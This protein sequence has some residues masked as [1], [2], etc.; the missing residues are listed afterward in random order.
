MLINLV[1]VNPDLSTGFPFYNDGM[2]RKTMDT[3]RRENLKRLASQ[4]T[5]TSIAK[6]MGW[7]GPS[8]VSQLINGHRPITEKTARRI[9]ERFSLD[10]RWMDREHEAI[11][12]DETLTMQAMQ[13]VARVL[14]E[15]G[16]PVGPRRMVKMVEIAV[17]EA[18]NGVIDEGVVR[19]MVELLKEQ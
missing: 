14:Q 16:V 2:P 17:E 8:Y 15:T 9:E 12:A 19:R 7:A 18:V 5:P 10:E 13:I 11:R 3:L 4:Q 1:S 6:T